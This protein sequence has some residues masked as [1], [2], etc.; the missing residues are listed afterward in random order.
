MDGHLADHAARGPVVRVA[1]DDEVG[2]VGADRAREP[3]RAEERPDRLGLADERV[4]DRRVVEEHDALVTAVDLD[5][6]ALERLHLERRLGVD[7]AHHRLAEVRDLRARE[8]A[9]EALRAHDPDLEIADL[10]DHVVAVEDD[11]AALPQDVL[12]LVAAAG[13]VVVIPEHGD[14]RHGEASARVAEHRRLLGQA[15]GREIARQEHEIALLGDRRERPREP[16]A[17]RLDRVDVARCGD[18]QSCTHP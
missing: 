5:E 15:M 10:E 4:R 3:P 9:D 13:V 2:P 11:D 12:Q 16:L 8:A 7:L 14:H 17:Q 18:P 6:A 1:V